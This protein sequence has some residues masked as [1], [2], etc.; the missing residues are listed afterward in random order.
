M[1]PVTSSC[2]TSSHLSV[3]NNLKNAA[4][5]F[6]K[7]K[8][9]E[10]ILKFVNTF[11]FT[12]KL[13]DNNRRYT[14]QCTCILQCVWNVTYYLWNRQRKWFDEILYRKIKHTL[15]PA[16]F[17]LNIMVVNIIKQKAISP[18]ISDKQELKL[19]VSVKH[20]WWK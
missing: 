9:R 5:T 1:Q 17:M 11:Q 14:L 7:H 20:F 18:S 2:L 16:Q 3:A 15:C 19:H 6:M 4:Q 10:V 8:H 13:D 12:L